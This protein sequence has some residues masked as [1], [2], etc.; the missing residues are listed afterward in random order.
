MGAHDAA[1]RAAAIG[2]LADEGGRGLTHRAVDRRAG[3]P[4]GTASRYAR[5]RAA[6]LTLTADALFAQDSAAAAAALQAGAVGVRTPDD[7]TEALIRVVD[8]L[9]AA[10]DRFRARVELQLEAARIPELRRH[11]GQGRAAFVSALA[12]LLADLGVR[13]ATDHADALIT[14]VD[15]LLHRE[16]VLGVPPLPRERVRALLSVTSD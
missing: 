12:A 11:F 9:R 14:V 8:H 6:L 15:G 13:G 2:V 16:V 3:L 4:Q 7:L 10:P 5:T 1:V